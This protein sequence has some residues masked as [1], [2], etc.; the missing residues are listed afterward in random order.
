MRKNFSIGPG[1]LAIVGV[2]FVGVL[3]LSN[4][5][6]RGAQLDLTSDRLYTISDGTENIVKTLK[7]PV[8]LYFFYS[9]RTAAT[10]PQVQPY[11]TRVRE[12][13]EKL[14]SRSNGK[15]T[16]KLIDPQPFSEEEDR[17][18]ELGIQSTP[19]GV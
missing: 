12:L 9:E 7:E 18:T 6:L 15:L 10:V 8:N 13:L 19:L 17:A 5:L 14:V 3:L 4:T 2:L 1:T 16:L 11:G